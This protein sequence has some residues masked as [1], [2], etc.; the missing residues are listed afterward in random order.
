VLRRELY[1][2]KCKS[3]CPCCG[4]GDDTYALGWGVLT[5]HRPRKRPKP[6]GAMVD[7]DMSNIKYFILDY[8]QEGVSHLVRMCVGYRINKVKYHN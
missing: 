2:A 6:L 5:S 8:L 1:Q 4:C 3:H 7:T